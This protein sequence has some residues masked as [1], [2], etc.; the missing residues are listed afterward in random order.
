MVPGLVRPS[1]QERKVTRTSAAAVGKQYYLAV[2]CAVS[3]CHSLKCL[4]ALKISMRHIV[5]LQGA[6]S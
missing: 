5:L 4:V 1:F 2:R 6:F 3:M